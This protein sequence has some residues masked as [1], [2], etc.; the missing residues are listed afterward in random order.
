MEAVA[1]G[2]L[3][4]L[5]TCQQEW[6]NAELERKG[7]QNIGE[8][9]EALAPPIN[10]WISQKKDWL[11]NTDFSPQ[12]S[13]LI[14]KLK[15]SVETLHSWLKAF[16]EEKKKAS[17]KIARGLKMMKNVGKKFSG[18]QTTY[19]QLLVLVKELDDN[20]KDMQVVVTMELHAG[21]ENVVSDQKAMM[22]KVDQLLRSQA[23]PQGSAQVLPA[24][25][26]RLEDESGTP[27]YEDSNTH[28]THWHPPT[29][30]EVCKFRF[31]CTRNLA[32]NS[33][34][35]SLSACTLTASACLSARRFRSKRRRRSPE[36]CRWTSRRLCKKCVTTKI[37]GLK[38]TA[39]WNNFTL[40]IWLNIR[41]RMR[42]S[43][44]WERTFRRI[45]PI[46]RQ[47][48]TKVVVMRQR[49]QRQQEQ[50]QLQYLQQ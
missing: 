12:D 37:S 32:L 42:Q 28:T 45:S 22:A 17:G 6:A 36:S 4:V 31:L 20:L 2:V 50:Q 19:D 8:R 16:N 47:R 9:L 33:F 49:Q 23:P 27:Y 38:S 18:Q 40:K 7:G 14:Q 15:A 29:G 25:W 35:D 44:T 21:I 41:Q 10:H 39:K 30:T 34:E 24:G 43:A 3:V 46:L 48:W 11:G 13:T 26:R 5:K 1:Q